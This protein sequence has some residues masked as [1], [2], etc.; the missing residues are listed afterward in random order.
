MAY[1]LL[2]VRTFMADYVLAGIS[3]IAASLVGWWVNHF[4]SVRLRQPKLI[5]S[6]SG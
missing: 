1:I 3:F 4:Y 5:Q 6:G 2:K